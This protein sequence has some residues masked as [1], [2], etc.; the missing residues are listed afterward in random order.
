MALQTLNTGGFHRA[1][2]FFDVNA[3]AA[4]EARLTSAYR[5]AGCGSQ[6]AF[7][8]LMLTCQCIDDLSDTMS[9]AV[10]VRPVG[11]GAK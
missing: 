11:S 1:R 2:E 3:L 9:P 6:V 7:D 10:R 8:A 5:C 4:S